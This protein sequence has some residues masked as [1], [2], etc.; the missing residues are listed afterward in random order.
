MSDEQKGL[1]KKNKIIISVVAAAVAVILLI[2]ILVLCIPKGDDP[3]PDNP[4][5]VHSLT[6]VAKKD[7]TCT[8][9]GNEAYWKCESC[10][11]MFSDKNGNTEIY[12]V[13]EIAAKGHSI[14]DYKVTKEADC[15]E[16]GEK[17]G[18]CD[19]CGLTVTEQI[20][21]LGHQTGAWQFDNLQHWKQCSRCGKSVEVGNHSFTNGKCGVCNYDENA[22]VAADLIFEELDDGNWAV[23][24]A[25]NLS[26][27]TYAEIPATHEGADVTTV[28]VKA[29]YGSKQ[30]RKVTFYGTIYFDKACF[31]HCHSLTE[32]RF[33]EGVQKILEVDHDYWDYPDEPFYNSEKIESVYLGSTVSS[34]QIA[35]FGGYS[36]TSTFGSPPVAVEIHPTFM[37]ERYEVSPD[38]P[39]YAS[40]EYGVLYNKQTKTLL[41]APRKLSGEVTVL[42][43][44]VEISDGAFAWASGVTAINLPSGLQKIGNYAFN[45][46]GISE[47]T[48]PDSV[49]ETGLHNGYFALCFNCQSLRK[50]HIGAGLNTRYIDGIGR[51]L[52]E[53]VTS[54]TVSSS[55]TYVK[56]VN[57]CI[58]GYDGRYLY[59]SDQSGQI[60]SGVTGLSSYAFTPFGKKIT[61]V[62]IPATITVIERYAFDGCTALQSVRFE[63]RTNWNIVKS[64]STTDYHP[65]DVPVSVDDSSDNVALLTDTYRSNEWRKRSA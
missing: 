52:P 5:H 14:S 64:D 19:V 34:L 37:F 2:V 24:G 44:T 33:E 9:K 23:T 57:N 56:S 41:F 7:A 36:L 20:P 50:L 62:T 53:S 35:L 48:I 60:P 17:F 16:K 21:A 40:D 18:K 31:S 49:T 4:S 38:N 6:A 59:L 30:L 15:T 46:T 32:V 11:K 51:Y 10:G 55:N 63:D 22:E 58:V 8:E 45:S 29:F 54:V 28:G 12:S 1:S 39:K 65:V 43:D 27:A 3:S 26:V 25:T 42:S 61:S 47:L 13:P